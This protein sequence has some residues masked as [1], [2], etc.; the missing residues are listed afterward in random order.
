MDT[1][2]EIAKYQLKL[3]F[4]NF[5]IMVVRSFCFGL[6]ILSPFGINRQKW[7]RWE[8]FNLNFLPIG[9]SK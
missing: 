8:P 6:N 4:E 9:T 3:Y 1:N 5:E 2:W 7:R